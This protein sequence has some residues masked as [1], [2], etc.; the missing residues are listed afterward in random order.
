VF[1]WKPPFSLQETAFSWQAEKLLLPHDSRKPLALSYCI[2]FLHFR[3]SREIQSRV[4]SSGHV[5]V[6]G[7][8]AR[9]RHKESGDLTPARIYSLVWT[10]WKGTFSKVKIR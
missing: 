8:A 3:V 4:V 2:L 9:G 10:L 6:K 1:R 7:P 5:Q